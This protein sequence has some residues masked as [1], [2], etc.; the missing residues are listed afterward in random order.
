MAYVALSVAYVLSLV[1]LSYRIVAVVVVPDLAKSSRMSSPSCEAYCNL[2]NEIVAKR[3]PANFNSLKEDIMMKT[4]ALG[5]RFAIGKCYVPRCPVRCLRF[6]HR[7]LLRNVV[8]L[9]YDRFAL[10]VLFFFRRD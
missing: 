2:E 8:F 10:V 5:P 1:C 7:V 9:G 3:R 6:I 4:E